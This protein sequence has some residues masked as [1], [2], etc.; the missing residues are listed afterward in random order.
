VTTVGVQAELLPTRFERSKVQAREVVDNLKAVL[1]PH[2]L[3]QPWSNVAQY[4]TR[5][6]LNLL[7]LV[8]DLLDAQFPEGCPGE[9]VIPELLARIDAVTEALDG[10]PYPAHV[11]AEIEMR[12][13]AL[14]WAVENWA[15][16]GA[17][18][19]T[20]LMG[21]MGSAVS[22]ATV[23]ALPDGGPAA[24]RVRQAMVS[25]MDWIG[26]CMVVKEAGSGLAALAPYVQQLL[27][28]PR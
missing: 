3:G 13:S 5:D 19:V 7:A 6:R 9:G 2:M 15:L 10:V 26:R 14:R 17:G 25:A 18:G 20:D 11:R 12:V 8:A 1:E 4:V 21:A 16:V 24:D 27:A 28:G 23:G 22:V